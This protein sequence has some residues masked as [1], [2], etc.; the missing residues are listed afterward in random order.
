[1]LDFK[2]L[3]Y[4]V[5][6][7]KHK[8]ITKAS[9]ELYI[10]QP[11]LSKY[12]KKLEDTLGTPLF[13]RI[14]HTFTLTYA[15]ERYLENAQDILRIRNKINA[16]ISDI[17]K[18]NKGRLNIAVPS[19]R[20]GYMIP[21][22]LPIFMEKYPHVEINLI[23]GPSAN[24]ETALING[25]A[26]LAVFNYPVIHPDLE[27]EILGTEELT[28]AVSKDNPLS[29]CGVKKKDCKYDWIDINLFKDENF[30]LHFPYQRTGQIADKIFQKAGFNPKIALRTRS[31]ECAVRLTSSNFGVC[32]VSEN[33]L[34]HMHLINPPKYFSIGTPSTSF[35]LVVAH[36]KGIYL[37]KYMLDYIEIL[38]DYFK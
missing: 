28:L 18:N 19:T 3:E 12:I 23:E 27:Y 26:D 30:I 38:K 32:F 22:T 13:N 11:S 24:A 15:G 31:I 17:C 21:E 16:E 35:Q 1:M 34:K 2:E 20:G 37:T 14:G 8:N 4:V 6:V 25:D 36:R 10:S 5:S 33:H 9:Q 29:K 7:A